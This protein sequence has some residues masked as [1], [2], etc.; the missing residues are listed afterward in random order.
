MNIITEKDARPSVLDGKR[1]VVA[2]YGNQGCPQ[3]LNLRDSGFDVVVAAR[4]EGKGWVRAESDGFQPR[5]FEEA[6]TGA[7]VVILLVPDEVQGKVFR[8]G[9]W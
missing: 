9:G 3:A 4:P 2:G 7:D 1:I 6:F 5:S 8:D